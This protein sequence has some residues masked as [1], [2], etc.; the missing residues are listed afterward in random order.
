MNYRHAF[1]AGNFADVFKHTLLI[2]LL[3]ALKAKPAAF[4]HVD[5]HAGR[6][7]YALDR[8]P[9]QRT[10]EYRQGVLRLLAAPALPAALQAYVDVVRSFAGQAG[11]ALT[12]YPGS[13]L[14]AAALMREQD[15]AIVCELHPEEAAA[16]RLALRGDRR[17]GVHQRDGYAAMKALL[18]PVQKRGLVL[19]DPPFEAQAGEFAIIQAALQQALARWPHAIYAVWYPIKLEVA[20]AP[21]QRWLGAQ[22]K[23]A[24]V[25]EFLLHPANSPLRLNGCGMVI[26]NPPWRFEQQ[27][28]SWLP[29]LATLLAAPGE[30]GQRVLRLAGA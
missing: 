9:A 15:R 8:G 25:A 12:C 30:G 22:G 11:E 23:D 21:F 5:T 16:L 2:G 29:V 17:F 14:V 4:C 1:H 20:V 27:L 26:I 7:S 19:I 3:N 13:P 18:P 28:A 24:I 6:G 10:G